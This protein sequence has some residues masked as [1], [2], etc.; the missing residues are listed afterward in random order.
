MAK[1]P[2]RLFELFVYKNSICVC[3]GGQLQ[4][5][6]FAGWFI[7]ILSITCLLRKVSEH[8]PSFEIPRSKSQPGTSSKHFQQCM[9]F[10]SFGVSIKHFLIGLEHFANHL[11]QH[12]ITTEMNSTMKMLWLFCIF[13]FLVQ[14]LVSN[15][16]W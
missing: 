2:C 14:I 15:F 11:L 16:L 9:Q 1:F 7:H 13:F 6:Y 12:R 3:R 5:V 8:D 4:Y 10:P